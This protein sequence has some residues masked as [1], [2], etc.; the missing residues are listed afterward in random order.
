[1]S[2][3]NKPAYYRREWLNA[4]NM[5]N[6]FVEASVDRFDSE[7]GYASGD[8]CIK[9]CSRQIN[10]DFPVSHRDNRENSLQ[11]VAI[12]LEVIGQFQMA[13]LHEA[14]LADRYETEQLAKL[15]EDPNYSVPR[16]RRFRDLIEQ[17]AAETAQEPSRSIPDATGDLSEGDE[18]DCPSCVTGK[19]LT[20][21]VVQLTE[22]LAVRIPGE[23][24]HA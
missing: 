12:L 18:C 2:D 24:S 6:A 1:M 11:K 8:L 13:L 5:G 23:V 21:R 19:G 20:D 4:P 10:L 15:A 7:Y 16:R 22:S 9:D 3:S 14:N 17:D